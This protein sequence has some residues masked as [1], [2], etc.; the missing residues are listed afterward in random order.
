VWSARAG[1]PLAMGEAEE[2]HEEASSIVLVRDRGPVVVGQADR[3]PTIDP[4]AGRTTALTAL[5]SFRTVDPGRER[6]I[7]LSFEDCHE[8][9]PLPGC[10]EGLT[11]GRVWSRKDW[12]ISTTQRFPGPPSITFMAEVGSGAGN[13]YRVGGIVS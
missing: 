13:W 1:R 5:P 12:F 2:H 8:T 11:S 4:L 7:R 6:L 10:G 3:A 9:A